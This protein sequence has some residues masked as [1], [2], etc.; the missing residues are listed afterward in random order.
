MYT[1]SSVSFCGSLATCLVAGGFLLTLEA[2][3]APTAHPPALAATLQ[4]FVGKY[5]A[6]CHN[7]RV[8]RGGLTLD[9]AAAQDV[10]Q[11]A[12]RLIRVAPQ[13]CGG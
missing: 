13:R 2:Q 12:R 3:Q 9:A 1:G 8:K 5:C 7:D 6:S 4:A 10:G 11:G